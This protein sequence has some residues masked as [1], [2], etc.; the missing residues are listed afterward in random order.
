[1]SAVSRARTIGPPRRVPGSRVAREVGA[2]VLVRGPLG[3]GRPAAQVDPLDAHPLHRHRLA[4]RVGAEG[5]D[6]LP[7]LEVLRQP[8][9]EALG[10]AASDRVVRADGA[11]LLDH[12]AC[13][14]DPL[15]ALEPRAGEP[16]AEFRDLL[17]EV[18]PSSPWPDG[19]SRDAWARRPRRT[20]ARKVLSRGR[21]PRRVT[22][23]MRRR[24]R[25]HGRQGRE[26]TGRGEAPRR[27]E[28]DTPGALVLAAR[29]ESALPLH[30]RRRHRRDAPAP[31]GPDRSRP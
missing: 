21:S 7:L 5:G 26:G 6:A 12:L 20:A 9:V 11:A 19:A 24:D 13:R 28:R 14:V 18:H 17:F 29:V 16:A 8:I 31:K 25:R 30:P 15:D 10:G 3:G 1:M 27:C 22:V 2:G 4:R 23:W